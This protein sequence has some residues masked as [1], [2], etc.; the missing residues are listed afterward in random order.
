MFIKGGDE[1]VM[2]LYSNKTKIE[3]Y[4]SNYGECS[5]EYE[6][7]NILMKLFFI[8]SKKSRSNEYVI[9]F[10][11]DNSRNKELLNEIDYYLE[12]LHHISSSTT[13]L[14]KIKYSNEVINN[15][16]I[17]KL[18]K[19]TKEIRERIKDKSNK[20]SL[21]RQINSSSYRILKSQSSSM[22]YT[23]YFIIYLLY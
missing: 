4:F 18:M 17:I 3:N 2:V 8:N 6:E 19:D 7:M 20:Q 9:K 21:K 11:G 23:L 5:L 10:R 15:E 16:K 1:T 14:R 22:K 12:E 13:T